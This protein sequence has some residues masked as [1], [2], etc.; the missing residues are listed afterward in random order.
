M[1]ISLVI[2]AKGTSERLPGKNLAKINGKSLVRRACERGLAAKMVDRVYLDTEAEANMRECEDLMPEM[3]RLLR[4]PRELATNEAT[5]NDLMM[6]EL[7]VIEPCDVLCQTFATSP[8]LRPD[9]IDECLLALDE[10]WCDSVLTVLKV[11]EYFWGRGKYG[12]PICGFNQRTL[13]NSVDMEPYYMETHGFYGILTTALRSRATR[14]GDCPLLFP[15][16][17]R[18]ALD[19]NDA[20]DLWIAER[21]LDD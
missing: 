15:V 8:M 5:G 6:W 7:S 13:P 4:R 10:G 17:K 21:L 18:E 9:T 1:N 3:V 20:E 19:I 11:Q 14:T 16:S 12:E 2:P